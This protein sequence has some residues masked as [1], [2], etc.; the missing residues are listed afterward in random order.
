MRII[1]DLLRAKADLVEQAAPPCSI[2]FV[3]VAD[4]VHSFNG[5]TDDF[6]DADARIEG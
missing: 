2:A 5:F 6:A 1:I 3:L 4:A